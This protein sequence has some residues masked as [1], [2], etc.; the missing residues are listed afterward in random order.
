[1]EISGFG[2]AFIFLLTGVLFVLSGYLVSRLI[3]PRKPNSVKN[4]SYECGEDPI[5]DTGM[6]FNSRFY[7][8]ALVFLIF[9]VEM[10]FIFPWATIFA[11]PN[12]IAQFPSWGWISLSEM[13][14]FIGILAIGLAYV[15]KKGDL[16]WIKPAP[17]IPKS[18]VPIPL[19]LYS[20]INSNNY[21]VKVYSPE[22]VIEKEIEVANTVVRKPMFKP[23]ILKKK[24]N[25]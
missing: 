6:R 4:S 22:K 11:E 9:D 12:I 3:S 15:W 10:V 24:E 23:S 16:E 13:F 1:M 8:I 7:V 19:E 17:L 21:R 25:G 14:I 5:K 20:S 18:N 2:Q